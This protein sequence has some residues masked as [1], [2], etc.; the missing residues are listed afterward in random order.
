[1]ARL[2]FVSHSNTDNLGKRVVAIYQNTENTIFNSNE[3]DNDSINRLCGLTPEDIVAIRDWLD[4]AGD[5]LL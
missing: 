1:M 5:R 2:L 3:L 4:E